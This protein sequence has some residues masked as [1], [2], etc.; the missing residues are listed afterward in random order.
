MANDA[1]RGVGI[2]WFDDRKL[3]ELTALSTPVA[4][5]AVTLNF[6]G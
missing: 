4:R 1:W 5:L 3:P 2:S 6:L